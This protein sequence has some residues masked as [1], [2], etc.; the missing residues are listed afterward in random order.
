MGAAADTPMP[1]EVLDGAASAAL[2]IPPPNDE[3]GILS[4][5]IAVVVALLLV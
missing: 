4:F 3:V 1:S 2:C 5:F